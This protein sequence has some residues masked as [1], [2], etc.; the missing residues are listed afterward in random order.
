MKN[1]N[2]AAPFHIAALK[3]QSEI[4]QGTVRFQNLLVNLR[5]EGKPRLGNN[6][7]QTAQILGFL[8]HDVV[9]RFRFEEKE[10]YPFLARHI[11]KLEPAL[12]MLEAEHREFQNKLKSFQR[13]FD[14]FTKDGPSGIKAAGSLRE[15]GT[16]LTYLLRHHLLLENFVYKAAGELRADEKAE[17]EFLMGK[18][19]NH[20]HEEKRG[21][22]DR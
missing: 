9:R 21:Q 20:G 2:S 7:R 8:K 17:L 15:T 10:I 6:I 5:Y 16:Y 11:P 1:G 13:S 14:R 18:M 22:E 4:L 19:K 3:R 12:R